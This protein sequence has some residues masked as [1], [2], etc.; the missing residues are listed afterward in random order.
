MWNVHK[1]T[2]DDSERINNQ[3]KSWSHRVIAF[4]LVSQTHSGIWHLIKKMRFEYYVVDDTKLLQKNIGQ[5]PK[6][7]SKT[8]RNIQ[9]KLKKL[10]I[11]Y[12]NG[13]RSDN[14][15][16]TTISNIIRRLK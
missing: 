7:K 9:N 15:F 1:T 14:N 2:L 8:Y 6:K 3:T 4:K 5:P 10:S 11:E 16:L 13:E 12:I